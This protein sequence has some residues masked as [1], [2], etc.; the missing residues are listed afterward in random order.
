MSL[1]R[2]SLPLL[3]VLS[4]C[5]NTAQAQQ[6]ENE[7]GSEE[8]SWNISLGVALV[9]NPSIIK[10]GEQKDFDEFLGVITTIDLY[11][12][13][14]FIQSNRNRFNYL[15]EGTEVG[16][17]LHRG[18][19]YDIDFISKEYLPGFNENS[20]GW[21]C[22]EDGIPEVEGMREREF[23][24]MQGIRYSR[25]MENAV[26]W[27]DAAI[28]I[29]E[30]YHNGWV[31]EGFYSNKVQ[32]QNWDVNYGAGASMFSSAMSN[33]YYS[34]TP[35]EARDDRSV[36]TPGAGFRVDLEATAR[37]PVSENWLFSTGIALSAYSSSIGKSPL[38]KRSSVIRFNLS[39]SYVF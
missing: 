38:I 34:V 8:F 27:V 39:I 37:Y 28:N 25:Y 9:Y 14:F 1:K 10:G 29:T 30:S 20:V 18:S 12:K 32:I 4:L 11:Y 2:F 5:C 3:L 6:A 24:A 35:A 21:H 17:E 36:Y 22:E 33:Y 15:L 7:K 23:G 31:I 16:Y 19:N 13:G 26:W